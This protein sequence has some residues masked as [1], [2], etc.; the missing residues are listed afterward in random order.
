MRNRSEV[1][2]L[3]WLAFAC[4]VWLMGAGG[5]GVKCASAEEAPGMSAGS[6]PTR[7]RDARPI[8]ATAHLCPRLGPVAGTLAFLTSTVDETGQF[9]RDLWVADPQTLKSQRLTSSSNCFDVAWS[10]DE[11]WLAVS[12]QRRQVDKPRAGVYLLRADG[13]ATSEVMTTNL[14]D[15]PTSLA[16]QPGRPDQIAFISTMQSSPES[17]PQHKH[18]IWLINVTTGFPAG[19]T[20]FSLPDSLSLSPRSGLTWSGDGK[21]IYFLGEEAGEGKRTAIWALTVPEGVASKVI[22]EPE[23]SQFASLAAPLASS[24]AGSS[25]FLALLVLPR[26]R[27]ESSTGEVS[28]LMLDTGRVRRLASTLLPP[29]EFRIDYSSN[30]SWDGTGKRLAYVRDQEIWRLELAGP[31]EAMTLD[32]QDNLAALYRGFAAYAT[33]HQGL[34]PSPGQDAEGKWRKGD[35]FWIDALAPYIENGA[36][37]KCSPRETAP[38]SYLFNPTLWGKGTGD[39]ELAAMALLTEVQPRH[40]GRRNV[41]YL[42]GGVRLEGE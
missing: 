18:L 23:D 13:T 24:S 2:A 29:V 19:L 16:W 11:V 27:V 25:R 39:P 42:N 40:E 10:P 30:L 9:R 7:V 4:A 6:I 12:A 33:A 17:N 3:P 41:L 37:L 20:C 26:R 31:A 35:F 28:L 1:L 32:C 38:S 15:V 8:V 34:L 5:L 36:A 22:E 21:E 14:E